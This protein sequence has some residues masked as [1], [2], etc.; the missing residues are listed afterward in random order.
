M[1]E[2]YCVEGVLFAVTAVLALAGGVGVIAAREPVHSVLGLLLVLISLAADY[3]LLGA[4]FIAALQ[5]IIYAGAIVVLFVFIVML[6][7]TRS[8]EGRPD[9][10]LPPALAIVLSAAFA[11]LLVAAAATVRGPAAS[12]GADYGTVQQVGRALFTVYA[13]PFEAASIVLI[14][15]MIGAV[16]LSK[17]PAPLGAPPARRGVVGR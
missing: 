9:R 16:A 7:N 12:V 15:G 2:A 17:R 3:L 10:V 13:L 4:Q 11:A 1:G 8:G 14:V 6:L 5:V